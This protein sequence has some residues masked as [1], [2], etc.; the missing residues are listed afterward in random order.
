MRVLMLGW[1]Y[2]PY[3]SGGLG[4]A[5][6]GLT[7]GL[8]RLG[9]EI[10]FVVPKV[11]G[12]EDTPHMSLFDSY[13]GRI[14]GPEPHRINLDEEKED[15]DD[16][17][18]LIVT[19]RVPA[20]LKPYWTPDD[21]K[22]YIAALHKTKPAAP[23]EE[24]EKKAKKKKRGKPAGGKY[25]KDIFQEVA[26]YAENVLATLQEEEFDLIHAHDWMT[27]PAGLALKKAT[28]RPLVVHVHSLEYDRS[29]AN[30]D[31]R[32]FAIER[33][34]IRSADGVIAVSKYTK[35]IVHREHGV[36]LDK[37]FV[38]Y[39]G[40]YP[41]KVVEYYRKESELQRKVVL[42]LGRVTFQKGPEYF[43]ELAARVVPHVPEVLF[44]MAG[45][46]DL[47]TKLMAK[48]NR[49]GLQKHFHFAG[50]LK[51][52][53][54]DRMFSI[55]DLYIMPSVSE[56]FG[57]SALEA[58]NFD[59]PAIISKQ[60]GVAEVLSHALKFDYWDVDT[61]ADY[62]VNGLI[63]KDLR[64]DLAVNSKRELKKLRWEASARSAIEVYNKVA[65]HVKLAIGE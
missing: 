24:K 47:L 40:I 9:V 58:V 8:A 42:F 14:S 60:S 62:V 45:T 33:M 51:G 34:G 59:T 63:H 25:G 35:W 20:A 57:I 32:I 28:G 30:V 44:V 38:V 37:I 11:Y 49:L 16:I 39:N 27:Y 7:K 4:T 26:L 36:P 10:L 50:F 2:P 54:V 22:S 29:G 46:G 31:P 56:P 5:C 19:Q 61:L 13:L 65:P 43:V 17:D 15:L 52:K 3:I 48:V 12:G 23:L 53:E 55:A 21:F 1:E 41:K 64:A 18:D 6:E